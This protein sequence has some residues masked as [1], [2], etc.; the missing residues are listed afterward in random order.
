MDVKL[1]GTHTTVLQ[2]KELLAKLEASMFLNLSL[3]PQPTPDIC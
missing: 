2:I 3:D 1:L